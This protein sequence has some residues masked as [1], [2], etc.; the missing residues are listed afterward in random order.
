MILNRILHIFC[1]YEY[2]SFSSEELELTINFYRL[3]ADELIAFL[4]V[5]TYLPRRVA[6]SSHPL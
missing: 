6:I 5:T 4:S 3:S 1:Y 2:Y